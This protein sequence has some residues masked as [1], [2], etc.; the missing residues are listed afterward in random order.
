MPDSVCENTVKTNEFGCVEKTTFTD[1]N[2]LTTTEGLLIKHVLFNASISLYGGH[3]LSWQPNHQQPVFWMSKDSLFGNQVGIR[4]GIPLCFPW[5]GGFVPDLFEHNKG[6]DFSGVEQALL[7]NHGFARTT[8]WRL[9]NI[10]ITETFVKVVLVQSDENQ[11]PAWKIPYELR[12]ELIFGTS[13]SQQLTVTNK[14]DEDIE[15]TGALHS[16]FAVGDPKSTYIDELSEIKYF[17]KLS[18]THNNISQ[19]KNCEGPIA[20]FFKAVVA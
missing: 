8:L 18:G 7:A 14:S 17:D 16:Y 6:I 10:E 3:V 5:F 13:F 4:G 20:A 11:S 2:S 15:Y 9:D 19:L 1:K 12:Q